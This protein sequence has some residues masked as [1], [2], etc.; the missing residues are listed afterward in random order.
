[1]AEHAALLRRLRVPCRPVVLVKSCSP[2]EQ[3]VGWAREAPI[4]RICVEC[5]PYQYPFSRDTLN[6]LYDDL[7]YYDVKENRSKKTMPRAFGYLA[8][9]TPAT[10]QA[11]LL[12]HL[13]FHELGHHHDCMTSPH[14]R[15]T[16]RGERYAE[17][18]AQRHEAA[19]WSSYCRVF[20]FTPGRP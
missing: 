17:E 7:C 11:L 18:Y 2:D 14:Q 8:E 9:F 3:P 10:V 15:P 20:L 6:D 13:L 12:V 5:G 4:E 16:T 19:I 1:Y